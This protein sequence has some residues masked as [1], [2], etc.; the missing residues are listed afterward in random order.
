MFL[1]VHRVQKWIWR[2]CVGAGASSYLR[3]N[4]LSSG[5]PLRLFWCTLQNIMGKAVRRMSPMPISE[6]WRIISKGF[7]CRTRVESE[8]WNQTLNDL[9]VAK[10]L[11]IMI[12]SCSGIWTDYNLS[13]RFWICIWIWIRFNLS[14]QFSVSFRLDLK[15]HL[16]TRSGVSQHE[17]LFHVCPQRP[18]SR[19]PAVV[20][21]WT[22]QCL[23]VGQPHHVANWLIK[24]R[25]SFW[26]LC[27]CYCWLFDSLRCFSYV[28]MYAHM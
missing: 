10:T 7:Q 18:R 9:C 20:H 5:Y 15:D 27:P 13:E 26:S 24:P 22:C 14:F 11:M 23:S 3:A 2:I 28:N 8:S 16:A 1:Q 21:D 4:S 12:W 25:V 6:C 17:R 19:Y